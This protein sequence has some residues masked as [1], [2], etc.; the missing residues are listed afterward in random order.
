MKDLVK[1][2]IKNVLLPSIKSK[3]DFLIAGAE[4]SGTTSLYKYLSAHPSILPNKSWKEVHYFD[5]PDNYKRGIGWY[6]NHFPYRF[7]KNSKLTFEATPY[8]YDPH[9]PQLI[10]QELGV[11]KIIIILREPAERAYSAWKMYSSFQNNPHA[12][13]RELHDSRSFSEAIRQEMYACSYVN[14]Y[15]YNYIDSGKYVYQVKR[16]YDL[17]MKKNVLI[18]STSDLENNCQCLLEEVC[19]FLGIRAFSDDEFAR[20]CS[21]KYNVGDLCSDTSINT[22]IIN[23][24]KYYQPYN[25][26]LNLLTGK[27]FKWK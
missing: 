9:I 7:T 22:S 20:N 2:L 4:K 5:Y 21:K 8:L 13:L 3:P 18:L 23:L 16:Y 15:P 17:F 6:L 27:D 1:D 24:K 12:H 11:I 19:D 25:E 14:A 10:L 26:D